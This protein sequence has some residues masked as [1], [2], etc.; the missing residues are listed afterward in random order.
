[1]GR[2]APL[3]G[4]ADLP[5]AYFLFSVDSPLRLVVVHDG[6]RRHLGLLVGA[7]FLPATV[8]VLLVTG[9]LRGASMLA[10]RPAGCRMTQRFWSSSRATS[11][12][13]LGWRRCHSFGSLISGYCPS[14][15]A[16]YA[17]PL[18]RKCSRPAASFVFPA[19]AVFVVC[20]FVKFAPWEWDNTKLMIWS[21]LTV[22]PFLWSELLS[23][24][25][26]PLRTLACAG[27]FTS[28]FIS[29]IG[30][31]D[32]RHTGYAMPHGLSWTGS[33]KGWRRF[34]RRAVHWWPTYN[35]PLL[36]VGRP[37]ALGYPG[38]VWSHGLELR[39]HRRGRVRD[40]RH[41][42]VARARQALEV[43]YLF[44][45]AEEDENYPESAQP[46]RNA[47]TLIASGEWG[48]LYDLATH[49]PRLHLH[50]ERSP[51]S[52]LS[53]PDGTIMEDVPYGTDPEKV[54]L[55]P[56]VQEALARLK[57]AGFQM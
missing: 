42:R 29:L 50:H 18:A 35:H 11:V 39:S 2:S 34:R 12:R 16:I 21:Y 45:G 43:R 8:L 1:V 9:M 36:L 33:E 38:H 24:W 48:E 47:A 23:R 22:L 5:S 53:R 46:W 26:P 32:S 30:G 7:A 19:V 3:R 25:T 17:S 27:L 55:F 28:G 10:G 6:A 40:E 31:L 51:T 57:A 14:F 49:H 37:M 20:C 52:R 41:A 4:N 54:R 44:W 56:A 13:S 15:W